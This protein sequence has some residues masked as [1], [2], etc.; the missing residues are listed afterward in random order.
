MN[1]KKELYASLTLSLEKIDL[2]GQ[3]VYTWI[4]T[5]LLK[6]CYPEEYLIF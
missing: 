4:K 1:V 2:D 6:Q 3:D 5:I